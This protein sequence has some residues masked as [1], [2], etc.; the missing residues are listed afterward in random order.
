MPDGSDGWSLFLSV[1][2]EFPPLPLGFGFT[3]N[4]VGGMVGLHRC[5]DDEAL[6]ERL[7]SGA[8]DSILFPEDPVA[9]VPQIISDINAVFPQCQDQFVFGA[10]MKIGWGTPSMV[11]VDLGVMVEL[12]DPFRIALLGQLA[13]YLPNPEAII[14]ELHMDVFGLID[15]SEGSFSLDAVLR[16]SHILHIIT[17]SGDMAM[18][19]RVLDNPTML[20]SLGGYHPNFNPPVEFPTLRR[21]QAALSAGQYAAVEVSCYMAFTS[22]TLQFGGRLDIWASFAGFTAEGYLEMDALIQFV[23]FG[24][25]FHAGFGVSVRAG[26]V[27]L[28]GVE[29]SADISGPAPWEI[30]GRASV[31]ILFFEVEINLQIVIGEERQNAAELFDVKQLVYEAL[32]DFESWDVKDIGGVIKYLEFVDDPE[33]ENATVFGGGQIEIAQKVAPL[34]TKL[35]IFGGGQIEGTKNIS[36]DEVVIGESIISVTEDD[37]IEDW[38]APA[39][40]YEMT[41]EDKI[42]SPSFEQMNSGVAVSSVDDEMGIVSNRS[43]NFEEVCIDTDL[44][45][46]KV[47]GKEDEI[48]DEE[49]EGKFLRVAEDVISPFGV[50]KDIYKVVDKVTLEPVEVEHLVEKNTHSLFEL[51][52][53]IQRDDRFV[54]VRGLS[55]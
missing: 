6:R 42:S 33:T 29:V 2:S 12:P 53:E 11:T 14:V 18:R 44:N 3:L 51:R 49:Q 16:D 15:F 8:L 37:Y 26:S 19:A 35:E 31:Q 50:A 20:L 36:I 52:S 38:F 24:F 9:N 54:V 40:Y 46:R 25:M 28:M 1:F 21:M 39:N 34:N 10:M 43:I 22:N 41:E 32:S 4:G 30:Y 47:G 48:L 13:A 23:P 45:L 27:S 55:N 5:L 7:L 17:L